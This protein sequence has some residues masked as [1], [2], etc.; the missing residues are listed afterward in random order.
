MGIGEDEIPAHVAPSSPPLQIRKCEICSRAGHLPLAEHGFGPSRHFPPLE[1]EAACELSGRL[2][3]PSTRALTIKGEPVCE[4]DVRGSYLAIF[5]AWFDQ[6]VDLSRDP[7][8]LPGK[9][10]DAR[11]HRLDPGLYWVVRADR[12]GRSGWRSVEA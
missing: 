11:D 8:E 5:L 6:Q 12:A 4:I 10:P 1:V 2:A 3:F 7:Y 9:R